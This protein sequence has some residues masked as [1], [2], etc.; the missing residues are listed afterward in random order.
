M[1]PDWDKESPAGPIPSVRLG[2]ARFYDHSPQSC[3]TLDFRMGFIY[4]RQILHLIL[5]SFPIFCKGSDAWSS[6]LSSYSAYSPIY[7]Y[8]GILYEDDHTSTPYKSALLLS[9]SL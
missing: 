2:S 6:V 7:K 9:C 8:L 4:S 5:G 1:A 3:W